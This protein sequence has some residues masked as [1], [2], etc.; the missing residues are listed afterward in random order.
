M[1]ASLA[2]AGGAARA[3]ASDMT[4]VARSVEGT[5]VAYRG[6]AGAALELM[7][8]GTSATDAAQQAAGFARL[9]Q[10]Q[11]ADLARAASRDLM[12]GVQN[13]TESIRALYGAT[14]KVQSDSVRVMATG[15]GSANS[16]AA[17]FVATQSKAAAATDEVTKS[18]DKLGKMTPN[19][20]LVLGYQL[21]D[22]F[23]QLMSGS[24]PAL[25][26]AQQGPQITQ[27][28]GGLKNTL[29]MIPTPLLAGGAA[30]L[31][32]GVY[33]SI[34]D[35]INKANDAIQEQQR[36]L[37]TLLGPQNDAAAAYRDIAQFA[38]E[39][40][41]AVATATEKFIAFGHAANSLGVTRQG[42]LGI[43][44]TAEKL[45]Q[46]SGANP[47]ESSAAQQ[48]LSSMLQSS[49]VSA[50]QLRTVLGTVPQIA[51][52]IAAGLGVSVTQLQ[53]MA[54]QGQLTNQQVFEGLLK[55][56]Q[57]VDAEF[58]QMPKS[59]GSTFSRLGIDLGQLWERFSNGLPLVREYRSAIEAIATASHLLNQATTPATPAQRMA[60]AGGPSI[61][62]NR[63]G[64]FGQRVNTG[65]AYYAAQYDL[66]IQDNN[67]TFSAMSAEAKARSND[68][69]N[70]IAMADKLDPVTDKLRKIEQESDAVGK[71]LSDLI[72]G[73]IGDI[74][75]EQ[76]A[77]YVKKLTDALRQLRAEADNTG[78]A[79]DQALRQIG[80]RYDQDRRSLTPAQRDLETRAQSLVNTGEMPDRA[81]AI[82]DTQQLQ[83]AKE[84]VD[85][86]EAE[87]KA[88][89]AK[90]AAMRNGKA[91]MIE[92]AVAAATLSFSLKVVAGSTEE[93]QVKMD[94]FEEQARGLYERIFKAQNAQTGI[95]ASK[96]YIDQLDGIAAAMGVVEQGA[97]A[98]KRA[99]AEAKAARADNG[100]GA[101]QM[102]VFDAQQGLTDATTLSNLRLQIDL[103]NKLAGAAG[104][105][106]RQKAIQ[107]DYD[108][109]IAQQNAAPAAR[110]DIDKAMR[111]NYAANLNR[112]VD[113]GTAALEKQVD[114]L[115]QENEVMRSG[116]AD[117]AAQVAMLQKKNDLISQGV[118]VEGNASA[119]RQIDAAGDLARL[120]Q[121]QEQIRQ[122]NE[123]WTA[124]LK[125]ALQNIQ[126][127]AADTWEKILDSGTISAQSLGEVFGKTAKRVAAE[128]LALATVRPVMSV[129]VQ[130][131][132]GVGLV[133][134]ATAAQLGYPLESGGGSPLAYSSGGNSIGGIG[135][136]SG[137][138]SSGNGGWLSDFGD[139]LHTPFIGQSYGG[140]GSYNSIGD[141]ISSGSSG[142]TPLGL[143]SGLGS[144]AM[145][146]Y[147]MFNGGG[148]LGST[149]GGVAG[150]AGGLMSMAG[151]IPGMSALGPVGMG[152]G[153]VGGLLG[154]LFGGGGSKAPVIP[155]PAGASTSFNF[156]PATGNYYAWGNEQNG[157]QSILKSGQGSGNAV[158]ALLAQ[159]GGTISNPAGMWG[160]VQWVNYSQ[161]TT[162]T[163]LLAPG[164]VYQ[165]WNL[166]QD[167]GMDAN[168]AADEL[169]AAV[170]AKN[171]V[172][173]AITNVSKTLVQAFANV[174]PSSTQDAANSITMATKYDNAVKGDNLTKAEQAFQSI[175]DNM[176]SIVA[177]AQQMGIAVQPLK[178]EQTRQQGKLATDF[179]KTITDGLLQIND[180]LQAQINTIKDSYDSAVKEAQWMSD[181]IQGAFIDMAKVS[182]YYTAQEA[183]A[184]QQYYSSA[185][186]SIRQAIQDMTYG[187]L[188][189]ASP[190]DTL[191]GS[192]ATYLA[193]LAQAQAGS[194][195]AINR[196]SSD[197]SS[198]VT[199][200]Q[201][202]Y[203]NTD[204]FAQIVAVVRAAL[205]DE[206]AKLMSAGTGGSDA[207][208]LDAANAVLQSNSDLSAQLTASQAEVAKLSAQVAEL[209]DQVSRLV[210]NR[211]A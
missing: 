174:T 92:A 163:G 156:N 43:T 91:A 117:Y 72:A 30:A 78:S 189:G 195:D 106:A 6:A 150:M 211:A 100:T 118:N 129:V 18:V 14:T 161:R 179:M 19:Q 208:S 58:Q 2:T 87:A 153:L 48:A 39:T 76:S 121:Q 69:V 143:V 37:G 56:S 81:A 107:L 63:T 209:L 66:G 115:R 137:L 47:N 110:D 152:V 75:S 103:T 8:A 183:A 5:E 23:T 98:M 175:N 114:V 134:P 41:V 125:Q 168:K 157:G 28:F 15:L 31:G 25:I 141:L 207:V 206:N 29:S 102:Q 42:I 203:G 33:A 54:T 4:A 138:F 99:E 166:Q 111:A 51:D 65:P 64:W 136:I 80:T 160:G 149:I 16:A 159:S 126:T 142:L 184:R 210:V 26:A 89:E 44:S 57:A 45:T 185:I 186:S 148:S 105:V 85:A 40:G 198:Y 49:T 13:S 113:E 101:L 201:N 178:D 154:G 86:L 139:W 119:Q 35:S 123:I 96:Q 188:S 24:S 116:S 73:N 147:S 192:R 173:G 109:K 88:E 162:S 181:N 144:I 27:I 79:A 70:T 83:T 53:L 50:D 34:L 38:S 93:A 7:R 155:P 167:S 68:L 10:Q 32:V 61:A 172:T 84:M 135:G 200:A 151:L 177:W 191:T 164:N 122:T 190:I 108:I 1:E 193:T 205:A 169:A 95:N 131:L 204:S 130:G 11:N 120:K 199:A 176:S 165:G 94:A 170:F 90:T 67:Q 60:A 124:P 17:A 59:L 127:T 158:M 97:Y 82:A 36:R 74:S 145:G 194:S 128:F 77:E 20:R 133:S 140:A 9:A 180:P 202:Y 197:A 62:P 21:N 55:Q 12:V 3:T 22:V 182:E 146:A 71:S 52:K 132:S 196:L 112:S 104:D 171:V 46:L 187:S